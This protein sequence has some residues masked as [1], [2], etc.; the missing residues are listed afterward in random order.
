LNQVKSLI[1]EKK[2]NTTKETKRK[3]MEEITDKSKIGKTQQ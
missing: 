2:E 3:I 1:G